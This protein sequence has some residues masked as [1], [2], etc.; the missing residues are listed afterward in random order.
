MG[1]SLPIAASI[2]GPTA[3]TNALFAIPILLCCSSTAFSTCDSSES[4][5]CFTAVAA[6]TAAAVATLV[7]VSAATFGGSD[8]PVQ[9]WAGRG[10]GAGALGRWPVGTEQSLD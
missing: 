7:R 4:A 3:F 10:C 8:L 6:A 5:S 2:P 9:V 1:F